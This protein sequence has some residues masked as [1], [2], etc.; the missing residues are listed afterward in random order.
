[1]WP[2]F[3]S[4]KRALNKCLVAENNEVLR[5][6]ASLIES[7]EGKQKSLF[8]AYRRS[9]LKAAS[10][11]ALIKDEEGIP[12]YKSEEVKRVLEVSWCTRNVKLKT[13]ETAIWHPPPFSEGNLTETPTDRAQ[14]LADRG[15]NSRNLLQRW[16]HRKRG[17]PQDQ[18][19]SLTVSLKTEFH[20]F[21]S[22]WPEFSRK[23]LVVSYSFQ[24]NGELPLARYYLKV[25]PI[26]VSKISVW[27]CWI[28]HLQNLTQS[29]CLDCYGDTWKKWFTLQKPTRG[30]NRQDVRGRHLRDPTFPC[31]PA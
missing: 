9:R 19:W 7:R 11:P 15:D 17:K 8:W 6:W 4:A 28:Q 21:T 31:K 26:T 3:W 16:N 27:L 20:F 23:F 18:T 14:E 13:S 24:K 1:M 25:V 22:C 5:R 30:A 29:F 2:I 10:Q 12:R